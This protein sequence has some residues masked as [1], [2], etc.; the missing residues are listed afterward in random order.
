M[1]VDSIRLMKLYLVQ[2]MI[3][4]GVFMGRMMSMVC[5]LKGRRFVP[6]AW[7]PLG[8]EVG[9]F[10]QF[11][12]GNTHTM[13]RKCNSRWWEYGSETDVLRM[14]P[15]MFWLFACLSLCLSIWL[16]IFAICLPSISLIVGI[17]VCPSAYSGL[18]CI[19]PFDADYIMRFTDGVYRPFLVDLLTL[20]VSIWI[21]VHQHLFAYLYW[22]SIQRDFASIQACI[23]LHAC[24]HPYMHIHTYIE[25]TTRIHIH[26]ALA[27][28]HM[29]IRRSIHSCTCMHAYIPAQIPTYLH[30]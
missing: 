18:M 9:H 20:F 14:Y 8:G 12:I 6:V 17:F 27:Q 4:D 2:H 29:G 26:C 13:Q 5:W 22:L 3:Y 10:M 28:V 23:R 1:I 15:G 25:K 24:M 21:F 30:T 11:L 19:G 7:G 16:S